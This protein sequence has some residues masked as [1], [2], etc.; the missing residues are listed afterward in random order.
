MKDIFEKLIEDFKKYKVY[1]IIF[2]IVVII[3]GILWGLLQPRQVDLYKRALQERTSNLT[4]KYREKSDEYN[5]YEIDENVEY[6]EPD[7]VIVDEFNTD[8]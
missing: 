4:D 7:G 1:I 5:E 8:E 2:Y 6:K 3:I